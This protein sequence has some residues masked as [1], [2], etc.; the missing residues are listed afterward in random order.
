MSLEGRLR[1]L[2]PLELCQMLAT[3]R[4]TGVL[5][6][7][8][9]LHA[10]VAE[11]RFLRGCVVDASQWPIDS[12][13]SDAL[14]VRSSSATAD[15]RTVQTCV[16]DLLTWRDGD[17]RFIADD[18]AGATPTAV[19]IALEPLL[20]EA[21][22]RAE[23]WERVADRV[24]HPRVVPAFL[25]VE[26]QQLPLL[27]LVP[28]EWEVLTRVDG[29][30]DL[31]ALADV[32]GRD[33]LD[34]AQIV[35]GLIGAGLLTLREPGSA[36]RRHATPPTQS[37]IGPSL[38]FVGQIGDLW[39]PAAEHRLAPNDELMTED[40]SIFD[41]VS[42]GVLSADGMPRRGVPVHEIDADA[43][44]A[45]PTT[46]PSSKKEGAVQWKTPHMDADTLCL[47]GDRA[48]RSGDLAGALTFWSASLRSV[49]SPADADRIREAIALAARLHAL[50]HPVRVGSGH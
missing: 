38:N 50:L 11:I 30:R 22:Q 29:R 16:L 6:V 41:P 37:A 28:Q 45:S 42:V 8:A 20:V 19:R 25:D 49:E 46:E 36:P 32:L 40:D 27:R 34:I 12:S 2:G 43:A 44:V 5:I 7:R 31:T 21:A 4:K 18:A 47:H 26:P 33:L 17:F 15:A 23:V 48:A 13:M 3:S 24:A 9:P 10:L 39:I 1:D 35:H 14:V